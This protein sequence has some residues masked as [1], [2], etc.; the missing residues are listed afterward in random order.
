MQQGRGDAV[1]RHA[2]NALSRREG[3]L[4]EKMLQ[5][6]KIID[7]TDTPRSPPPQERLPLPIDTEIVGVQ[8]PCLSYEA[9]L[10]SLILEGLADGRWRDIFGGYD[11]FLQFVPTSEGK[12]IDVVLLKHGPSG[13]VIWYQ[14]LELKSDKYEYDHLLQLL[15]YETWLTSN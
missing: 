14:I 9:A 6:L 2:Y 12:E 13:E 11:D 3:D 15:S 8:H 7:E 10:Q 1:G 5:E 4:L